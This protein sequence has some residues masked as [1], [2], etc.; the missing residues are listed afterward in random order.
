MQLPNLTI[1]QQHDLLHHF[2]TALRARQYQ[3]FTTDKIQDIIAY[4]Q[5]RGT[6]LAKLQRFKDQGTLL[7]YIADCYN[8]T[9]DY[10]ESNKNHKQARRIA[11]DHGFYSIECLS[12]RGHGQSLVDQGIVEEGLDLLRNA[13]IAGP[14][15]EIDADSFELCALDALVLALVNKG[16]MSEASSHISRLC[17]LA[18][19]NSHDTID[20]RLPISLFLKVR[21]HT[22]SGEVEKATEGLYDILKLLQNNEKQVIESLQHFKEIVKNC[23]ILL[24]SMREKLLDVGGIHEDMSNYLAHLDR[25]FVCK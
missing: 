4:E 21:I 13:V 3:K 6:L 22:A 12:C 23:M 2:V 8:L 1:L 7:C 9:G 10:N 15:C 17:E 5:R 19:K 24:K 11:E 16:H 18:T 25:F 20:I 14:L